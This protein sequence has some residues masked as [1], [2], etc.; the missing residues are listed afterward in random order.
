MQNLVVHL[1]KISRLTG[2]TWMICRKSFFW[3]TLDN[4]SVCTSLV[5]EYL[6]L[7]VCRIN[8]IDMV[9]RKLR[10]SVR[11]RGRYGSEGL[12]FSVMV[13]FVCYSKFLWISFP[14]FNEI[15][16]SLFNCI[17]IRLSIRLMLIN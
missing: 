2:Y 3:Q 17:R 5:I 1:T 9:D 13:L 16:I 15:L 4:H 8:R 10:V 7:Q 11:G 14:T 6:V 12:V